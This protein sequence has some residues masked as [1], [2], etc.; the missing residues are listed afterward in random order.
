MNKK[1]LVLAGLAGTFA[2]AAGLLLK[3]RYK[4]LME[5]IDVVDEIEG[6]DHPEENLYDICNKLMLS[7]NKVKDEVYK[8]RV[9]SFEDV[10]KGNK[11]L[12][13]INIKK[14]NIAIIKTTSV[15]TTAIVEP[16][17]VYTVIIGARL[18]N[19][20]WIGEDKC[21][22]SDTNKND[23]VLG[24]GK[25]PSKFIPESLEN[26]P[27]FCICCADICLSTAKITAGAIKSCMNE[28]LFKDN[29]TAINAVTREEFDELKKTVSD[30]KDSLCGR[31][32]TNPK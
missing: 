2:T 9:E 23:I 17:I 16:F 21:P 31:Q 8:R 7:F 26:L 1:N 4:D 29:G 18:A 19:L 13:A 15:K 32:L 12:N 10:L 24:L 22:I 3:K 27:T 6:E 25:I 28:S 11:N 30:I 20:I 14:R 5:D